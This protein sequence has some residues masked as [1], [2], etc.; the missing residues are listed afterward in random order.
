MAVTR[1]LRVSENIWGT[2]LEAHFAG[3]HPKYSNL[4]SK[5]SEASL[6]YQ[7]S[8]AKGSKKMP[9]K[10]GLDLALN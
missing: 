10:P 5:G 8:I 2:F 7:W 3:N 4:L 1:S 6:K 9:R